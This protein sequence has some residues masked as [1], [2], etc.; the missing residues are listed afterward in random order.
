MR[1]AVGAFDFMAMPHRSP[2]VP[3]TPESERSRRYRERQR[4]GI[5]VVP[6]EVGHDLIERLIAAGHIS[7]EDALDQGCLGEVIVR[8]TRGAV[9]TAIREINDNPN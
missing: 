1:L 3:P 2:Q 6:V 8:V 7:A 9:L 5:Q 4:K